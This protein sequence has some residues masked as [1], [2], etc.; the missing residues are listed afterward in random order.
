MLRA[1]VPQLLTETYRKGAG[2]RLHTDMNSRTYIH[3][4]ALVRGTVGPDFTSEGWTPPA[5]TDAERATVAR[6]GG[7]RT[8][9]YGGVTLGDART[10]EDLLLMS[11]VTLLGFHSEALHLDIANSLF[12]GYAA[13]ARPRE[14][15]R[16]SAAVIARLAADDA[17]VH[18][19]DYGTIVHGRAPQWKGRIQRALARQDVGTRFTVKTASPVTGFVNEPDLYPALGVRRRTLV[20]D[21]DAV[22]ID[23]IITPERIAAVHRLA[24]EVN[25]YRTVILVSASWQIPDARLLTETLPHG[26]YAEIVQVTRTLAWSGSDLIDE[27]A[28]P[29]RRSLA[30]DFVV[31]RSDS[32]SR[33]WTGFDERSWMLG[34]PVHYV[35][36]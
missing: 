4:S 1:F 17:A 8:S 14:D 30:D 13:T 20:I 6:C 23:E 7:Y 36:T 15:Q 18:D 19:L 35:E 2:D 26:Q 32:G 11:S 12:G 27:L 29:Y 10:R 28:A 22:L 5:A 3:V 33:L 21:L 34:T 24:H 31:L 16:E 9:R 25:A